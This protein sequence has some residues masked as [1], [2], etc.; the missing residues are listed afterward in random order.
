MEFRDPTE[1]PALGQLLRRRSCRIAALLGATAVM[2]AATDSARA[3][4][5]SPSPIRSRA[6]VGGAVGAAEQYGLTAEWEAWLSRGAFGVGF[7]GSATD[8]WSIENS[9]RGILAGALLP[10]GRAVGRLAAG[11]ASARRCVWR[12]EQASNRTCADGTSAELAASVDVAL[13]RFVGIHT[14]FFSLPNRSVGHSAFVVGR[15]GQ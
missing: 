7:Q 8:N 5:S 2:L 11:V 6:W 4:S 3:Q 1:R 10:Y 9:A 13:G 14:S 12:G 15:L